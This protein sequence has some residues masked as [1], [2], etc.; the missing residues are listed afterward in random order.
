MRSASR[1]HVSAAVTAYLRQRNLPPWTAFYIRQ[2]DVYN[3]QFGMSHFNW[4]VDG[5][6]YCILRMGCYPYIK[7]HCTQAPM[8]DL[9]VEN[10]F[11]GFLKLINLGFPCLLYGLIGMVL[12]RHIEIL[13]INGKGIKLRFWY[14][15]TW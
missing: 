7:Y 8:T 4:N 10:V 13:H 3:D 1:I 9:R 11:Y 14:K 6:N 5:T 12:A 15:E 2:K